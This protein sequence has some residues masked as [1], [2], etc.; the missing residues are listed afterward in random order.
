MK[1]EGGNLWLLG[2]LCSTL[3]DMADEVKIV[4]LGFRL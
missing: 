2:I 3:T 1:L 4:F